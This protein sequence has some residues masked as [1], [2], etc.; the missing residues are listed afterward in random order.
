MIEMTHKY[1]YPVVDR[2][3]QNFLILMLMVAVVLGGAMVFGADGETNALPMITL[4]GDL[5][6]APTQI[7]FVELGT[8]DLESG[9]EYELAGSTETEFRGYPVDRYVTE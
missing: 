4:D 2:A 5:D 6:D 8:G 1:T 9:E 3:L 7:I